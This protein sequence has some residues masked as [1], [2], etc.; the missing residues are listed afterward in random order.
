ME[1]KITYYNCDYKRGVLQ[2]GPSRNT[3][4]LI[5]IVIDLLNHSNKLFKKL[6]ATRPVYFLGFER[7]A[8]ACAVSAKVKEEKELRNHLEG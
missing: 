6:I 3:S 8:I 1:L 7:S 4:L 5:Y 2:I